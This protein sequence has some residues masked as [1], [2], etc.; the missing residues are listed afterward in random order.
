MY[1]QKISFE[2]YRNLKNNLFI[3]SQGINVIYGD[4]AQGK[5]NLIEAIWLFTGGRSFRGARDQELVAFGKKICEAD[6]KVLRGRTG[7][8]HG[9]AHRRRQTQRCAQ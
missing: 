3:P 6:T 5:T 9:T 2:N 4:N 8:E 1:I 7:T